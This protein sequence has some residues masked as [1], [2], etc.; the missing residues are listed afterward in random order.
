[1]AIPT[2]RLISCTNSR[3]RDFLQTRFYGTEGI[4]KWAPIFANSLYSQVLTSYV[5]LD[6]H[7]Y[8]NLSRLFLVLLSATCPPLMIVRSKSRLPNPNIQTDEGVRLGILVSAPVTP[9]LYRLY[10]RQD[11]N[12]VGFTEHRRPCIA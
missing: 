8:G 9:V 3:S 2:D 1:M 11:H 6:R 10:T 4:L 12:D 7:T 5:D